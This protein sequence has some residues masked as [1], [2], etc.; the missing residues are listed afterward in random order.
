MGPSVES[1][2]FISSAF[3]SHFLS[4][5][6]LMLIMVFLSLLLYPDRLAFGSMVSEDPVD[7]RLLVGKSG[8]RWL[9]PDRPSGA[10]AIGLHFAMFVGN[11]LGVMMMISRTETSLTA[12][13][14]SFL[15][16]GDHMLYTR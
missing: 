16:Y 1:L 9:F 6:L 2:T 4:Q 10:P 14:F 15:V 7:S 12:F 5:I 3:P 13:F 8:F 11:L